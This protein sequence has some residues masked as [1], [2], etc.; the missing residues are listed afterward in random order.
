MQPRT[1][2]RLGSVVLFALLALLTAC[3]GSNDSTSADDAA[4]AAVTSHNDADVMFAQGMIPHHEQ[5]IAMAQMAVTRAT[6]SDVVDLANQIQDA[7]QPEIDT[8]T[9]WL[10]SWDESADDMGGMDHSS[11][12]QGGMTGMMTPEDMRALTQASGAGFDQMWLEMMI[13]HHE[14]A[15]DMAQTE[16]ADGENA[17]AKSLAHDIIDAQQAEITTMKGLL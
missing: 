9:R 13:E 5:A 17:A 10:T 1:Q 8:M 15:I 12:G 2:R 11:M 3:G 4:S 16:L 6:D 14:G 7:Q